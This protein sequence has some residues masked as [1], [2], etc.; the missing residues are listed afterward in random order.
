[1]QRW[2]LVRHYGATVGTLVLEPEEFG[3][4]IPAPDPD[5]VVRFEHPE[6][7]ALDIALEANVPGSSFAVSGGPDAALVS[8]V[9]NRLLMDAKDYSAPVDANADNTIGFTLAVI[10]PNGMDVVPAEFVITITDVA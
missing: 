5:G 4:M 3:I 2:E 6:G 9:D 7:Q 10:H 8:V 1:M